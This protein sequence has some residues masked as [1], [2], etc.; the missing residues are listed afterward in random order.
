MV[1]FA[2]AGERIELAHK[3]TNR[4]IFAAGAIRAAL[5]AQDKKPGFYSMRDV[6]GV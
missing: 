5:W 1:V 6:L 2:G 3:A 4:E